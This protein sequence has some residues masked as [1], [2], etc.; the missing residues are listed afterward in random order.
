M[1]KQ[2]PSVRMYKNGVEID[3]R[4]NEYIRKRIEKIKKYTGKILEFEVEIDMDKKGKFRAE[5]MIKTPYKL[6]RVEKMSESIEGSV[7][8][9]VD[10]LKIQITK[11]KDKIKELR[12]RG[13]IS[14]KK[15]L[16]VDKDAR[17]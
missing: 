14:L 3:E 17:F 16:V 7:D 11:D 5:I 8:V 6:Y 15:K 1:V 12:E 4:T 2:T 10:S 9:A 13:A